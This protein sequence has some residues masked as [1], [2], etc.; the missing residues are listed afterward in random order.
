MPG[1]R[2]EGFSRNRKPALS[3]SCC[4]SP[5]SATPATSP[6]VSA[7][8]TPYYLPIPASVS[9]ANIYPDKFFAASVSDTNIYPD[10]FFGSVSDASIYPCR[11]F[12]SVSGATVHVDKFSASVSAA[13]ISPDHL[14]ASANDASYYL[15]DHASVS[16]ASCYLVKVLRVSDDLIK[17]TT[18]HNDADSETSVI[19]LSSVYTD[20]H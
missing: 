5:A 2:R 9:D 18:A 17:H 4:S 11:I 13:C 10:K 20:A 3:C 8:S 12:A 14:T 7:A 15:P 6:S 1:R 19:V 16:D